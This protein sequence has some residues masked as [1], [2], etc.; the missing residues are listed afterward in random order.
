M[1]GPAVSGPMGAPRASVLLLTYNHE[2]F[3]AEAV[4][5][6]LAQQ[7]RSPIEIVV[8][9]DCSTDGTRDALLAIDRAH[10]GRLRLLAR[11]RN[12]GLQRNFASALAACR[13]EFVA[14]LDGDDVWTSPHKLQRQIDFL[15]AHPECAMC[16][17][18]AVELFEDGRTVVTA[19]RPEIA[20]LHDMLR[21][22]FC[23]SSSAMFRKA[24]VPELPEWFFSLAM[25]DQPAFAMAARHGFIG[26]L[27]EVMLTYRVH[28]GGAWSG[29]SPEDQ[30]R[31][32][33]RLYEALR[34]YLGAS[35]DEVIRTRIEA[36]RSRLRG[37]G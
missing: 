10:P 36:C 33:V 7:T 35:Y 25:E 29:R 2:R 1:P 34:E 17:H 15:D 6:A 30:V 19:P 4:A 32:E 31:E 5:G 20:T 9:E 18:G 3:I 37:E 13:G 12:Y 24:L 28:R 11:D 23:Y 14:M 16:C 26:Y 8:A 21:D 27:N 22:N